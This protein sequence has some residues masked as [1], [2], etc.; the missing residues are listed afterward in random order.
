MDSLAENVSETEV[1]P[2]RLSEA[3]R[4][5]SSEGSSILLLSLL[6]FFFS[7]FVNS[8][9]VGATGLGA[10][11][12]RG[13]R[14]GEAAGK[15]VEAAELVSGRLAC[16]WLDLADGKTKPDRLEVDPG[17]TSS[18]A[19]LWAACCLAALD[20]GLRCTETL[21]RVCTTEVRAHQEESNGKENIKFG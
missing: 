16:A 21:A 11:S 12:E 3:K 9:S 5:S 6:E 17:I 10:A 4:S 19:D 8:G 2:K 1:G 20:W 14:D 15:A 18:T 13:G 7:A